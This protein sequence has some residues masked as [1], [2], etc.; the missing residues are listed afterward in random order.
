MTTEAQLRSSYPYLFAGEHGGHYFPTGWLDI[1]GK[2]YAAIDAA[3]SEEERAEVWILQ[4]KEKWGGLRVYLSVAPPRFDLMTDRGLWSGEL[5]PPP[6]A[7]LHSRLAPLVQAAEEE[8]YR[9]CYACGAPG[10]LRTDRAW[11]L[12][13]C[14]RHAR[15]KDYR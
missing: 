1:L 13:L 4:Q 6:D 12:T 10:E 5:T 15:A 3:L 9:T 11:K 14:D 2:L 7:S 8:S